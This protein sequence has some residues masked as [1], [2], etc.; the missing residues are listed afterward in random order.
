MALYPI[1]VSLNDLQEL[2]YNTYML[3]GSKAYAAACEVYS[4]AKA[5]GKGEIDGSLNE[6]GRRFRRSRKGTSDAEDG[7]GSSPPLIYL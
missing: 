1:W 2:V 6:M 7:L 5:T 4:S 3:A